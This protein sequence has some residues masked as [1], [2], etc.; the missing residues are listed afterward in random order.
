M[1]GIGVIEAST[2]RFTDNDASLKV[3]G[4]VYTASIYRTFNGNAAY[5]AT[6]V[7]HSK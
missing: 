2:G 6:G 5:S 7:L 4:K 3:Y 1:G